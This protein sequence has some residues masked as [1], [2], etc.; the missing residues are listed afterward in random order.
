MKKTTI[1]I[2][3]LMMIFTGM[4][5]ANETDLPNPVPLSKISEISGKI[6][7]IMTDIPTGPAIGGGAPAPFVKVK[8]KDQN[9]GQ[10]NDVQIAPGHFLRLK[11]VM[12]QKGDVIKAKIFKPVNSNEIKSM[13]IEVKGKVLVLRDRYGKGVWEKPRIR[14]RDGAAIER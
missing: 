2:S 13:Q 12:L 7:A 4:V 11:G 9:T 14:P 3:V 10:E 1:L 6:E 5:F 8:I